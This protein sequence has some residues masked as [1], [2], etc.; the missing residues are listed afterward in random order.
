MWI[1]VLSFCVVKGRIEIRIEMGNERFFKDEEFG[2][3]VNNNGKKLM[4]RERL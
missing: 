2:I 4:S 1:I 3:C